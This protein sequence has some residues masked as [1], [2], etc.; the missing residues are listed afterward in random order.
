MYAFA[1][2]FTFVLLVPQTAVPAAAPTATPAPTVRPAP[3]LGRAEEPAR[4]RTL[5]EHATLMKAK[6]TPVKPV[7]FDDVKSVDPAEAA[8]VSSSPAAGGAG[9]AASRK[10]GGTEDPDAVKAQR[11]MDKAV[12]KGL[13]VPER[14]RGSARDKARREWDEAAE[15][16][17]TTPGCIP[18]YRDDAAYGQNK[19]LKTD[20]ELIE[21]IRKRGFSEPHPLPK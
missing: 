10:K 7:S 8:A 5:S 15:A 12:E 20:Q 14:G 19:P 17:R 1:F 13:A 4:P 3:A 21:E 6:G 18:R 9:K 16:C 11:R 2:A